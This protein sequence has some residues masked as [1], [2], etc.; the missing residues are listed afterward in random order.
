MAET[1]TI[2]VRATDNFSGV[3][4][5][6]GNIMTGIRSTILMAAD[7]FGALVTPVI[8]FGKES[9]LA[10]ARV[11]ELRIVNQI[12][13]DNAGISGIA[14]TKAADAVRS[15]GI[16]AA[17]SQ[18][19]VAEFIK[20]NLDIAYAADVA[21]V[22]QDAAVISGLNSTEVTERIIHGITTLNPLVLRN[23]GIIVD[24]QLAYKEYAKELGISTD[25]LTTAEK[26]QAALNAVLEAGSGIAGAYAAAM[27]EPGK[28]LRSFPRYFDDIKVAVGE[29]FQTVFADVIFKLAD[30]AKWVAVAVSEGGELRPILDDMA[31]AISNMVD[32]FIAFADQVQGEDF[33][34]TAANILKAL[35]DA[36]IAVDWGD[37]SDAMI[38]GMDK[39]DWVEVGHAAGAGL[40]KA[41][42][43]AS[44]EAGEFDLGAV[45]DKTLISLGE[46][47]AG[48]LS[49]VFNIEVSASLDEAL[50]QW[51]S[52]FTG[53]GIWI[54][55]F[56]SSIS[57]SGVIK[58]TFAVSSAELLLPFVN[59]LSA[60]KQLFGISS[61]STVFFQI[62][63]DLF[64][65]LMMGISSI[66][67]DVLTF[68]KTVIGILLQPFTPLLDILGIATGGGTIGTS[69]TVNFG[70]SPAATS[71][72]GKP[73]YNYYYGP[74]YFGA[75]GEPGAYYDCPSPNP[76]MTAG[77][78]LLTP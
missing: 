5:N 53:F 33:A 34:E 61:P 7:A 67:G 52:F 78:G 16:E 24:L 74:V 71:A 60:V 32:G 28:V 56:F 9:V 45:I 58:D 35:S 65:G 43:I 72:T 23:A 13:A 15:M 17:V 75:A 50:A 25:E 54:K 2:N 27:E 49:G 1:V 14:V 42:G 8:D 29:S 48:I 39:V 21:R 64:T 22:S 40:R 70:T 77:S 62:G 59:F 44:T 55:N 41:L 68:I 18:Q 46:G 30:F 38:A 19:V 76:F 51:K 10:A 6:F 36:L 20:A 69:A 66:V 37:V 11:D 63:R 73:V 3:L 26:Q 47:L 4:G 31:S 12:L 57:I